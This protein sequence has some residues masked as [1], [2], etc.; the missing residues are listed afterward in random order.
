MLAATV[1]TNDTVI[2]AGDASYDGQDITIQG[3]TVAINGP[4]ALNSVQVVSA[5]VLT[6]QAASAS[7]TDSLDLAIASRL[8]VDARSRI[9]VSGRG[10]LAY[11]TVGNTTTNGP[12]GVSGGSYGGLGFGSNGKANAT[13]GDY[14]NPNELGS[15]GAGENGSAGGGGG[16]VRISAS[17]AQIDGSIL[18]NGAPG[19]DINYRQGGGGSGGGIRL[20]AGTLSGAGWIAANGGDRANGAASGGGGRVAIYYADGSGF[21]LLTNVTAHGGNAG[22]NAGAVGTVYLK[23]TGGLGQLRLDNHGAATGAWTPLGRDADT[24]YRT[25]QLVIA[26]TNVVAMPQHEMPILADTLSVLNGAVLTHQTT[27]SGQEYSLRITVTNGLLIDGTSKM[28]V[29]GRGY[30]IYYTV[31]NTNTGGA[32]GN[33]GGSYGGLGFAAS[34]QPNAT[35]GDYRNPNELGS[36]GAGELGSAGAGGGLLRIIADTAQIDGQ[37]LANGAPGLYTNYRQGGGGSGGGIRLDVHGLSGRGLMAANGGDKSNGSA[38]GGGGRVAIYFTSN[39][40]FDLDQNVTAHGGGDGNPAAVGTVYWK[41]DGALGQLRLD[42]HGKVTGVWTPLGLP[43]DGTFLADDLVING[44]GIVAAPVREMPVFVNSLTLTNG[45]VL[46]HQTT[47]SSQEYSLR[48]TVT[49]GLLIDGTSKMDVSGRGYAIYYTV[50]NT[51]TGGASG[52]AGGSY[53]GLGFAA[54]G[55]PNATYG[56]YRNPNELGSG[57]AGELGSAGKGGGL[58]RILA[59]TAQIDGQLLANGAPGQDTNYRQGGGGSGGGIRLDVRGLSGR[60]LIAANGGGK[61][62]GSASGGGGRVAIYFTGNQGFDL[63]QNATA[64]GG[65]DGNPAAVG[66]VYWKQAGALGQLRLDNHGKVTGVWTPL[67]LPADGSFLADDLVISGAG[68]V[69][70]P[71]REMPV[72]VNSLTLTNGAVLTHQT[73]T[74][75]Q[76]YSLRI[77][78]ANGLL[79]DGTSKMDVS[80]RGY[81]IYYTLGNT[82]TGGASGNAGGSYGGLGYAA[83]GRPNATYGDYRNPDQSGSGGAGELGSAGKGGGLVRIIA[84]S[85]QINGSILANGAPGQDTNYRQGG[86]GSGGGIRLDVDTLSGAGLLAANGGDKSNGSASGGGGRVAIYYTTNQDFDLLNRVKVHGG[87]AGGNAGAVGTIYLKVAG[88]LARLVLATHG[89]ATGAWT[90]LGIPTDSAY[91]ADDLVLSGAGMVAAPVQDM[92]IQVHSLSLLDGAV[93]KHLATTPSQEYSLRLTVTNEL[94]IDA[95]SR[96]DVT[97]LGYGIYYSVGNTTASGAKGQSGGSYGGLGYDSGGRANTT[98]GDYRD[99]NQLGSGGAGELGSGGAGGGLVR[100]KAARA[101]IEGSILA[102]G[103][104]GLDTNYRQG[105]GGSGGAVR[106]DV[107]TLSGAG[108]IAANGGNKSNGSASGG[109]GRVAIYYQSNEDFDLASQAQAHS[110]ASGSRQGGVGTVFSQQAGQLGQL[111]LDSHGSGAGAWTP[112]GVATDS[113]FQ[114]DNLIISGTNVLA[115]P[116]HE[117]AIAANS[118]SLISG[119]ALSHQGVTSTQEYSLQLTIRSNFWVDASSQIDVSGKGYPK[120]Y[121]VGNTIAGGATGTSGGSYG[122]PGCAAGGG[123][124]NE[125]YGDF[126]DPVYGGSGGAGESDSAGNGGGLVR[127]TAR[128]AQLDGNLLAK[129]SPGRDINYRQ[130]GGGSGGGIMLNVGSLA[131][132]GAISAN[133]GDRGNGTASGGGGRIAI[134]TWSSLSFPQTNITAS[135]GA[136][137]PGCSQDGTIYLSSSPFFALDKGRSLWHGLG[138]ISWHTAG[139][140]PSA[141]VV[142]IQ[143]SRQGSLSPLDSSAAVN[144]SLQWDTTQVADG[145]YELRG[146]LLDDAGRVLGEDAYSVLVNN[147]VGWHEGIVPADETWTTDKAHVVDQDLIIPSGVTVNLAPGTILKIAKGVQIVVQAGGTLNALGEINA[148][149]II[150]SLADDAA[151]GDTNLDGDRSVPRPGDWQIA[152]TGGQFNQNAYVELRY[153]A[154]TL[155]GTLANNQALL[156]T[157]VYLVDTPV[158]VPSGLTLTI[159]PGAILKFA[160]GAG[161]TVNAGGRLLALGTVAQPIVFTSKKDDT[162]GGDSNDDGDTTRPGAGDWVGINLAS[163]EG[164]LSHCHIRYGGATG[165]GS[166]ASGVLIV[167]G[168]TLSLS[169]S[170][171]ETALYDGLSVY[172][173]ASAVIANSVLRDLARAIWGYGG[174]VHLINCTF[175]ENLAALVNHGGA[176]ITAENCVIANSIQGSSTEGGCTIRYCDL[177]S[178]H[179]GSSNP[180]NVIGQNGNISQDPRFQDPAHADYRLDYRS[181][182]ID[183]A[184]TTVAPATDFMGAPRYRDPRTQ[185][186]SG[187][188]VNGAYADMGAFEFVEAAVSSVDL[189]ATEVNGPTAVQAGDRATVTWMVI[190]KGPGNA[191][192]PW[193]DRIALAP[194]GGVTPLAAD[195]ALVGQGITLGPGEGYT[196]TATVRVPSGVAGKYQWQVHVNSQGD[197]FEGANWTNNTALAAAITTLEVPWLRLDGIG[198]TN[199]FTALNQSCSFSFLPEA[200]QDIQID[201]NLLRDSGT[202]EL[203]VGRGYLPDPQHYDY[204]QS[205][206][207]ATSISLAIPGTA[208]QPYY[209]LVVANGLPSAPEPFRLAANALSFGLSSVSPGVVGNAGSATLK[210]MGAQLTGNL[211]FQVVGPSSTTRTAS[212]VNVVNETAVFATF[213]FS[214]VPLGKYTLQAAGTTASLPGAITVTNA[215]TAAIELH[216]NG[217]RFQRVGRSSTLWVD[218]VNQ[219]GSDMVAPIL[220]LRSPNGQFRLP[221]QTIWTPDTFAILAINQDGPAGVLPPG[222]HGQYPIEFTQKSANNGMTGYTVSQVDPSAAVDWAELKSAL[223]PPFQPE[224][225]WEP[226]FANFAGRM[227]TTYGQ[228]QALLAQDATCLSQLGEWIYDA[229]RLLAFELMIADGFG[230]ISQRYFTGAFGRGMPDVTSLNVA[231]DASGKAGVRLNGRVRVFSP[232][233]S[234]SYWAGP[235][236]HGVLTQSGGVFQLREKDGRATVFRA[237]GRLDYFQDTRGHRVSARY[238]GAQLTS[239]SDAFGNSVTYQYDGN[240]RV[241]SAADAV[242]RVTRFAYDSSS[243]HLVGISNANETLTLSWVTGQG[244]AREHAVASLGDGAGRHL[245][246]Q[247]DAQ[248]R[249]TRRTFDNG[250]LP[251]DYTY[252]AFGGM[253]ATDADGHRVTWRKNAFEQVAQLLDPLGRLFTRAFDADRNPVREEISTGPSLITD[254]DPLGN[255]TSIVDSAGQALTLAYEE[256]FGNLTELFD[257]AGNWTQW[258]YNAQGDATS[259]RFSDGS[260]AQFVRDGAGNIT[261]WTNRRGRAIRQTFNS[262]NQLIATTFPDQAGEKLDYDAHR[263]L[264]SITNNSGEITFAYDAADRLTQVTYPQGR[265]LKFTYDAA[266]RRSQLEDHSGFKTLYTYDALGRLARLTDG[267]G[268]TLVAYSYNSAGLLARKDFGNGVAAVYTYHANGTLQTLENRAA[269]GVVLSR[270]VYGYDA[271]ARVTSLTTL[272]GSF[273]YTYD[274]VGQL[275]SVYSPTTGRLIRYEYD[276]NGNRARVTDGHDKADFAVNSLNQYVSDGTASYAYDADGNLVSK[277]DASGTTAYAYDDLSRLVSIQSSTDTWTYEYDAL[278]QRAAVVHNGQRREYLWDPFDLGNVVAEYEG[279]NL[280]A[281]YAHAADLAGRIDANGQPAYYTFDASGNT[282]EL[283]D[284]SGGVLNQYRYLPFGEKLAASGAIPNPFTYVGRYGVM[285]PGDGLYYMRAR[286]YAAGQGRFLS[287]DPIKTVAPNLYVYAENSPLLNSDPSGGDPQREINAVQRLKRRLENRQKAAQAVDKALNGGPWYTADAPS[288]AASV[289]VTAVTSLP[290]VYGGGNTETAAGGGMTIIGGTQAATFGIVLFKTHADTVEAILDLPELNG[291]AQ[292]GTTYGGSSDPN[293]KIGPAGVGA[294]AF[295]TSEGGFCYTIDFENVATA[296]WPAQQVVI[297]DPLDPNLDWATFELQTVAFNQRTLTVPPGLQNYTTEVSVATD[298]NPVLVNAALNPATGLA[299]WTLTSID[300]ATSMPVEDPLAGFLPPNDSQHRGEGYVTYTVRAKSGLPTGTPIRN[301]ANI[302]FDVNAPILT[303]SITNT[304]DVTRPISAVTALPAVSSPASFTVAW[305]GS[306]VGSGIA[307]Y[308]VYVSTDGGPWTPWQTDTPGTSG[309]FTGAPGHHYAFYSVATD[310]VGLLENKTPQAEAG[311]TVSSSVPIT[312]S[313]SYTPAGGL[314]LHVA[315]PAGTTNAI[316]ASTDLVNWSDLVTLVNPTG[317]LPY[318][319]TEFKTQPKRFYRVKVLNP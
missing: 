201:L 171:V 63:A 2:A 239:L 147:T 190:N 12:T 103:A 94:F 292:N 134:Y 6:H 305:S 298:P 27:T 48:I 242:G 91:Q 302:V 88:K 211:S 261:T 215:A 86:G 42:N 38:S 29:S 286:C 280:V 221:G 76:E 156:G 311:T 269:T 188:P 84:K 90:P 85:A 277:T 96:I 98:Y 55:Q 249:L 144:G 177:W 72:F 126:H 24:A 122:G 92:P 214:G 125:P 129:G 7:Q 35:Y 284:A 5:G 152:V 53:G 118:V 115:M 219:G 100:I 160:S 319:E 294:N 282:A 166:F 189:M 56:D 158:I 112:L 220:I 266:G 31:G 229:R 180:A 1:F 71:A 105:G 82:N 143:V 44:A 124:P 32:S 21:N 217:P 41:P 309:R 170:V 168:G 291:G 295:V 148:P 165:S 213:D 274:A 151:G 244:A 224:D 19:R 223:K 202:L 230:A 193:H 273:Q 137:S 102:N 73:T 127:I 270:F 206:I 123:Q 78:V 3:C 59:D 174:T 283:T 313:A 80:G 208:A 117:L 259:A 245:Y 142:R 316:Q 256:T 252:D 28:D 307:G 212:A 131:G 240:G 312:L 66:T 314:M 278:G 226:I 207:S 281:H 293:D 14:R 299:T 81:A 145:V 155:N 169:N 93:L 154:T 235:G 255:P 43:G 315:G 114:V 237:D 210:I 228:L 113:V 216:I 87:S 51:N 13:Y 175:D 231:T 18:A 121:T 195:E 37:L 243:Q 303:P 132:Q 198:I 22:G 250:A 69:A 268:A 192:G 62:N 260:R 318:Q 60:G 34:G 30:A 77:T 70:A 108:L 233:S 128:S 11:H 287:P 275:T 222:Y 9:D 263:N 10:Y 251:I 99:P 232:Q 191:A 167:N 15:G 296:S 205:Q 136:G 104:P 4:H 23:P 54:S 39:Q 181:P 310:K 184:D 68:I 227:G 119:A 107:D 83:S 248:G 200:G 146:R 247:Y 150:T 236:D 74:S 253:T 265:F 75:S 297:T 149:I 58:V 317:S 65:G 241:V 183:A 262:H 57:G 225:S 285:D 187:R 140:D 33:A 267:A 67:G 157:L 289:S 186:K 199:N 197:I 164:N 300:P 120:Y 110:G 218:Y 290:A 138:T 40:G 178:S 17:I 61:S 276:G 97:S 246:Y 8:W 308:S 130:G 306:D 279:G 46:T 20:E 64:H 111:R 36:G 26:G 16:L 196:A 179:A 49:N 161:I 163:A 25:E 264:V 52:N 203:Y 50:G 182:A 135:A 79:I 185:T 176:G 257:P 209:V 234:G 204:R 89:T 45:A 141:A 172:N 194:R 304:L 258:D 106:L 288:T 109:G 162:A 116:Q 153:S 272:E 173:S 133:G 95:S 271:D 101:H 238:T 139:V 254:Y 47:T 301:Q 159:N